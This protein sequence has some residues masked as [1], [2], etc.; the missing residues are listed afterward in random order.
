MLPLSRNTVPE[1]YSR[2]QMWDIITRI[3]APL[4]QII[5]GFLFGLP[6]GDVITASYEVPR[7]VSFVPVDATSGAVTITLPD[8]GEARG[9]KITVKKIDG[10]GNAVTVTTKS[11]TD[12]IDGATSSALSSQYDFINIQSAN[13]EYWKT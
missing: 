10:S 2:A 7:G 13:G 5:D 12:T 8:P 3:A 9:R 6:D 1:K 4:T 11:G